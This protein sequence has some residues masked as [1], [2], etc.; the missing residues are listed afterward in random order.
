[1]SLAVDN[2]H[3]HSSEMHAILLEKGDI[4]LATT[5][6]SLRSKSLLLAA[7]SYFEVELIGRVR[8]FCEDRTGYRS[9]LSELIEA[10]AISR[11]YHTWFD[12]KTPSAGPFFALFGK[13]FT[14]FMK[15]RMKEDRNLSQSISDFLSIGS[16]RNRLVHL[17]FASFSLDSTAE[18]V[19]QRYESGKQF[20]CK[21][22]DLLAEFDDTLKADV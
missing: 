22:G 13:G 10:K 19:F 1:M 15:Q 4:S 7:A 3:A 11:Q 20:V 12:W 2:L 21:I 9:L 17:D 5:L 8:S 14:A 6:D 18:E 16:D